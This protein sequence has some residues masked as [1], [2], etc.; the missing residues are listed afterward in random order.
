MDSSVFQI[1]SISGDNVSAI[2][3]YGAAKGA[4]RHFHASVVLGSMLQQLSG[5]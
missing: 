5:E 2:C 4:S 1:I 3:V